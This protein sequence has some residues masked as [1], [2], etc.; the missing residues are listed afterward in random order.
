MK[1]LSRTEQARK[2]Q[3]L[4]EARAVKGMSDTQI[5]LEFG[6]KSRQAAN[7]AVLKALGKLPPPISIEQAR[8]DIDITSQFIQRTLTEIIAMPPAVHSA[9]GNTII[10]PDTCTCGKRFRKA[11]EHDLDCKGSPIRDESARIRAIG[12]LRQQQTVKAN[13]RVRAPVPYDLAMQQVADFIASLPLPP[14]DSTWTA[15]AIG[16][17]PRTAP[18]KVACN[19]LRM[20]ANGL[21][22]SRSCPRVAVRQNRCTRFREASSPPGA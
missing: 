21:N 22:P 18:V 14:E 1:R 11:P 10:D 6:Y 8:Q 16:T 17:C 2:E 20:D 19:S 12:E 5:M 7:R 3:A 15:E 13:N 9:I 4:I